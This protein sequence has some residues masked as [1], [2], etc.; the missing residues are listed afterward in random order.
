[1]SPEHVLGID[2]D[3]RSDQFSFAVALYE[4]LYDQRPFEGE[5]VGEL[6]EAVLAGKLRPAPM[7]VDV[8]AWALE[9]LTRALAVD[10]A[11]RW[12]SMA[13]LL[14]VLADHPERTA[15]PELDRTVAL[16]Q[17]VWMLSVITVG[18]LGLLGA[19]LLVRLSASA[20][21]LEEYAFWSKVLFSSGTCVGLVATK[22][23]FEKNHYNQRVFAMIMALGLAVM[24][25]SIYARVIGLSVEET[26]R[27]ALVMAATVFGQASVSVGRWLIAIPALAV[28]G[29]VASFAVPFVASL[30]LGLCALSGLGMTVYF[31]RR[32]RRVSSTMRTGSLSGENRWVES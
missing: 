11:E 3:A 27:F 21:G 17:R 15:D 8:P 20:S 18:G 2:T 16:R 6:L 1:M 22:H 7:T 25:I 10:P 24:V 5:S 14:E 9:T 30:A 13:E 28:L 19:L 23:V 26:D 31:W 12:G 29:L 32:R 4:A